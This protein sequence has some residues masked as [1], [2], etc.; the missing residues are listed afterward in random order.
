MKNV[1]LSMFVA[2]AALV[3][4]LPL[5]AQASDGQINFTGAITSQTC[6]ISGDGQGK[7]F[8]VNLPTLSTS[9]LASSG[10]TA[11]NTPFTIAL[12]NCSPDSGPV[13][14]YFELGATVDTDSHQLVNTNGTAANVQIQLLNGSDQS[15]IMLGLAEASQNSAQVQIVGG[16]ANLKYS[17]QY[18]TK[19]GAAGPGSVDTFVTYS[20]SYN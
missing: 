12:T 4:A 20:L 13:Q 19:G 8:T 11:G 10:D 1:R 14:T 18:A 6:D 7:N 16:A 15:Q 17:A 9:A 5:A 3:S 2:A